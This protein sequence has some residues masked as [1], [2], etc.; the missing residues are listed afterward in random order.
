MTA[1]LKWSFWFWWTES[2]SNS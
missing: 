2:Q 1:L